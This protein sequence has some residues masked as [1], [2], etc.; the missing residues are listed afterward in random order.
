ML[1]VPAKYLLCMLVEILQLLHEISS[2]PEVFYEKGVLKSFSKSRGKHI[3]RRC[4]VKKVLFKISQNLQE[5]TCAE[6][7]F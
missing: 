7:S 1:E 3:I 5:N 2:L 6:V 4:S